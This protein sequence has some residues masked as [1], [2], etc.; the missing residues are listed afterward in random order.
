MSDSKLPPDGDRDDV[1]ASTAEASETAG[2]EAGTS[3]PS[4]EA[5]SADDAD[6]LRAQVA[7]LEDRVRRQQAEFVNDVRRIQRQADARLRYASEPVVRDLLGVVDALHAA[8]EGLRE[9]EHEKRVAE[10]LGH[11]ERQLIDALA[12]HGVAR[13]DALGK[14]FDPAVHEAVMETEAPGP[15]RTVLQVTRPGFTL[16]GRVVRPASVIVSKAREE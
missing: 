7:A 3:P 12:R 2:A 4:R 9:T 5:A 10:G 8:V 14:P 16:H 11:V 13:I 1:T 15:A 6:A